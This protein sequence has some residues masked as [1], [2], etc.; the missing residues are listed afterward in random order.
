MSLYEARQV[1]TLCEEKFF[2]VLSMHFSI[3]NCRNFFCLW[4]EVP[5]RDLNGDGG[6]SSC[7]FR[8][9][10]L[11]SPKT[12]FL[13]PLRGDMMMLSSARTWFSKA[14]RKLQLCTM[15]LTYMFIFKIL[16]VSDSKL[17]FNL[18]VRFLRFKC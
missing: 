10:N 6:N 5:F 2:F 11:F 14:S 12:L 7:W 15:T 1:R 17:Y 9:C 13:K 8:I 18:K 4:S 3:D 16:I